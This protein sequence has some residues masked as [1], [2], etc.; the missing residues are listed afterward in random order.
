MIDYIKNELVVYICLSFHEIQAF[1]ID[2]GLI[3]DEEIYV[4]I[5]EWL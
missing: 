5:W 4:R 2:E 3:I 1:K